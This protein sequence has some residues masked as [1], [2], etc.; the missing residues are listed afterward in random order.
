[1][2]WHLR[3]KTKKTGGKK[4][5]SRDK[6][7]YEIGSDPALTRVSEERRA[8]MKRGLGGKIKIGLLRANTA[9][10]VEGKNTARVRILEVVENKADKQFPR[11]NIITKGAII[12]TEKGLARVTNRPG[13]EGVVNAVLI[14]EKK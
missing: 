6:K 4:K 9:N 14:E 5:R 7:L 3:S 8:K 12:R 2:Q 13:Q 10:L 1:M 11:R